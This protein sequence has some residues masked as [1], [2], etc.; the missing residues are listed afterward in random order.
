MAALLHHLWALCAWG[1]DQVH[2]ASVSA[3][4]C[5]HPL[6]F[7]SRL[8]DL[9][10]SPET[11]IPGTKDRYIKGIFSV[12]LWPKGKIVGVIK[13]LLVFSLVQ[14]GRILFP[15]RRSDI[16][17]RKEAQVTCFST[18]F[19]WLSSLK[20]G[21]P[22]TATKTQGTH[23][24]SSR[25]KTP[26]PLSANLKSSRE[27]RTHSRPHRHLC[28]HWAPG[29]PLTA[30]SANPKGG[31][32]CGGSVFSPSQSGG[33]IASFFLKLKKFVCVCTYIY[34]HQY[35]LKHI[36]R[37]TL[38]TYMVSNI[39]NTMCCTNTYVIH[40]HMCVYMCAHVFS[41]FW[42]AFMS[43]ANELTFLSSTHNRVL[44]S[45]KMMMHHDLTQPFPSGVLWESYSPQP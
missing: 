7:V 19:S 30:I 16:L 27:G 18:R 4:Y 37:R 24:I 40:T 31:Q 42:F 39:L 1:H 3:Q 36:I 17:C 33:Y 38:N 44:K 41:K 15:A 14:N 8:M 11:L 43:M 23:R 20:C 29:M 35:I 2:R 9:N 22:I 6:N 25:G 21:E 26:A 32:E 5:W 13:P 28:S 45:S 12:S 34:I 10:A